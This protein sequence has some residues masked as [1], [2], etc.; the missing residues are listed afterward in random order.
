MSLVV[1]IARTHT[2]RRCAESAQQAVVLIFT[3]SVCSCCNRV[4]PVINWACAQGVC[5]A[6]T[7]LILVFSILDFQ[8]IFVS[9][10]KHNLAVSTCI[11]SCRHHFHCLS[12]QIICG[13][14]LCRVEKDL[15][16]RFFSG[17]LERC[18]CVRVA[19]IKRRFVEQLM[20]PT[21]RGSRRCTNFRC[22]NTVRTVAR[23]LRATSQS[24]CFF[25]RGR[26][27]PNEIMSIE[28]FIGF[29]QP[30]LVFFFASFFLG[31]YCTAKRR[32]GE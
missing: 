10:H 19:V 16:N 23:S 13:F 31:W 4:H 17:S 25:F 30:E 15:I 22:I 11:P 3:S 5:Y 1:Y 24:N 21:W 27:A 32:I 6:H 12:A 9:I 26:A 14:M 7:H 20:R 29:L 18:A 2:Y 8:Y 28:S